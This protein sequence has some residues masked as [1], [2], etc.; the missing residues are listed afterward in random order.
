MF[1][2][3]DMDLIRIHSIG[4]LVQRRE[5]IFNMRPV[6]CCQR[7]HRSEKNLSTAVYDRSPLEPLRPIIGSYDRVYNNLRLS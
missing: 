2:R 1:P 7:Y 6:N 5:C 4:H 3:F